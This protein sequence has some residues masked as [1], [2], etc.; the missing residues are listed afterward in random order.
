[1]KKL[2]VQQWFMAGREIDFT[3]VLDR[4]FDELGK[5]IKDESLVDYESSYGD[6]NGYDLR[7]STVCMRPQE[8]KNIVELLKRLNYRYK[9]DPDVY[10]LIL[11]IGGIDL[12][13]PNH[14]KENSIL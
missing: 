11:Y 12:E 8:Y 2:Q 5:G 9:D 3:V 14:K 6:G 10:A 7:L 13:G 4:M 1:M